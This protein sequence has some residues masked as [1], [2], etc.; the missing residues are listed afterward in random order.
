MSEDFIT[1]LNAVDALL[2]ERIGRTSNQSELERIAWSQ[3]A[4]DPPSDAAR[5]LAEDRSIRIAQVNDGFR[6]AIIDAFLNIGRGLKVGSMVLTAG[7]NV[8]EIDTRNLLKIVRSFDTFDQDNDPYGEH[9]FGS[10]VLENA[11]KVFWK[12]DVFNT[13]LMTNG[14]SHPECV[15]LSYR[16]LTIM[17]AS[18]Y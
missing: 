12:I 11:G 3:E 1:Y 15:A 4:G 2:E 17:L 14:A 9:D 10:I 7:V 6:Q 18:E 8:P 13:A 5:R 16:V